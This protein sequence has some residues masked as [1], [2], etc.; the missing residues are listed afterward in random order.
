MKEFLEIFKNEDFGF[1]IFEKGR[2]FRPFKGLAPSKLIFFSRKFNGS[3]CSVHIQ[4]ST[5]Q[6]SE[7]TKGGGWN[8]GPYGTEKSMVLRGLRRYTPFM[9]YFSFFLHPPTQRSL[10]P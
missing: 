7:E 2:I 5:C 4:Y 6:F 10:G 3:I 1:D 8:P 9:M